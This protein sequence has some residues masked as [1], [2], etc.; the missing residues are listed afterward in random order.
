LGRLTSPKS[1]GIAAGRI[2]VEFK[3][4]SCQIDEDH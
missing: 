1:A 4:V 3:G 2:K